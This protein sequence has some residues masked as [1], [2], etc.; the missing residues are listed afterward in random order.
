MNSL[1]YAQAW[2]LIVFLRHGQKG[3][4]ADGFARMLEDIRNGSL[5]TKARAARLASGDPSQV[6]LGEA[7]FRAYFTHDLDTFEQE[8]RAYLVELTDLRK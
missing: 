6:S 4:Y 7:V 5:H 2:A 3:R 8:Y 1:Y